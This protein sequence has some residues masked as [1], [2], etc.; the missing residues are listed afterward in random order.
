MKK[1]KKI[2]RKL[3]LWLGLAS[4]LVVFVVALSGSILVFEKEL[5][6]FFRPGF[7]LVP[8]VS[9]EKVPVDIL[10]GKAEEKHPGT[11]LHDLFVFDAP[12]RSVRIRLADE[13]GEWTV[14]SAD[15]YSGKILKD[16][17]YKKRFFTIVMEL[18]RF[19]LMGETGK[20]ITGISCIIFVV[21][22]SSGLI[23]WWPL[24]RKHFKQRLNVKWDAS[25]KRTNWDFHSVFGFYSSLILLLIALTGL[26]WSFD[27]YENIMYFLADGK[28]KPVHLVKNVS[29]EGPD[30]Q[31]YFYESMLRE[32]DSLF[33]YRG[34]IRLIVPP[35]KDRSILVLKENPE[36]DIPN[37]RDM[38]YFDRYSGKRLQT[39]LYK[40]LSTGD[41]IRRLVYP[42]HI[43]S[44]YGYPTRILAFV[45]C[46]F[47]STSPITGFLI[48]RGRKKKKDMEKRP[49]NKEIL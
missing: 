1:F 22:L 37:V 26:V 14:V 40:D 12:E 32:T 33:R 19:L 27:W 44:I 7:H 3:H 35:Q 39:T 36:A 16:A 38:V 9:S 28:P 49:A 25:F 4:G 30:N 8:E 2:T 43:G 23:L 45:V 5:D 31:D 48:W 42:I 17:P 24:K 10:I 41:K 6:R 46:L 13:H 15:P 47:A 18:H 34:D 29:E 20:T 21:L 11:S